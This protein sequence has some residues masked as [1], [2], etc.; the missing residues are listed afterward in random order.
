MR[1][2]TEE[3]RKQASEA[4]LQSLLENEVIELTDEELAKVHGAW[5]CHHHH[6]YNYHYNHHNHHH[7]HYNH[8][9][10]NHH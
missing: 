10:H 1:F 5:N 6:H 9:H 4:R 8:H 3:Q 7:H 2:D